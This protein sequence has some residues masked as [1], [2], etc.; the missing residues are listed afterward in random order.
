M[1]AHGI[2][3]SGLDIAMKV[4]GIP[5]CTT[6][7]KARA[8]LDQHSVPHA[9]VDFKKT[10]PSRAS[11]ARWVD[12]LGWER[13]LNRKGT[14]WRGLDPAVQRSVHDAPTAIAVLVEHPSIIK[15][16]IV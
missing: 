16:P 9:F 8:W 7:R 2:C 1:R 14:T 10:P 12:T 3:S 6:V 13:V 11:V 15:R 5:N 4:Y